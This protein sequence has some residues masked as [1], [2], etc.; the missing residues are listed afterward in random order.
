MIF[1]RFALAAVLLGASL[2][3]Q[4]TSAIV[5]KK[6]G[7]VGFYTE[8]GRR[9]AEAR[10]GAFPQEMVFSPDQLAAQDRDDRSG[11]IAEA[12]WNCRASGD[13]RNRRDD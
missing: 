7:K 4:T 13:R 3:S 12:A 1:L 8:E 6:A 9:L 11:S 5:E 10:V 2:H